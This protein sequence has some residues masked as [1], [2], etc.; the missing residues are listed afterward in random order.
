[1]NSK[2]WIRRTVSSGLMVAILATYSMVALANDGKATGELTVSALSFSGEASSVTVNGEAAKSG[3]TVFSSSTIVTPEN[4]SAVINMGKAGQIEIAPNS[5]ITLSFDS[6]S[7]H[8]DL[9]S[10]SVTVL[11]SANGV[12]VTANGSTSVLPAGSSA[13]A[14]GGGGQTN[15]AGT[16]SAW[17][18]WAIVFGGAAVGVIVAASRGNNIRLGGNGTVVSPTR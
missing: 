18:L 17:W 3:R 10:G 1:M 5:N 2:L 14:S 13:S 16:G 9:N 7:A 8:A 4:S 12:S 6:S 15:S 11:N